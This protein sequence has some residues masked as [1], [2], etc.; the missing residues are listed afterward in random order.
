[1]ATAVFVR[2][3]APIGAPFAEAK[4]RFLEGPDAWLSPEVGM[5]LSRQPELD[6]PLT[7]GRMHLTKRARLLTGIVNDSGNAVRMPIRLEAT[8]LKGLFPEL[9]A[10]LTLLHLDPDLSQLV[11]EGSYR[12]PLEGLG[13][14]L[15][16]LALHRVAEA[17][18]QELVDKLAAKLG[19]NEQPPP[20]RGGAPVV[21]DP[22][23]A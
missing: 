3:V 19:G 9:D 17:T 4:Q 18:L 1:M 23:T 8:G 2:F 13:Q 16:R 7:A 11:L 20:A 15:D 22:S 10:D 21:A 5:A 12:P 6:L 14:T